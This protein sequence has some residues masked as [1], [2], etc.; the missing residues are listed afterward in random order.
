MSTVSG[1]RASG[2]GLSHVGKVRQRNEDSLAIDG[3]G[4]FVL[5]ADGMGGHKG[6]MEASRMTIDLV[7]EALD[8]LH[9]KMDTASDD[10]VRNFL[11]ELF[12]KTSR[13]VHD[14]GAKDPLLAHMGTTLVVWMIC[15]NE[16]KLAHVGD[17]RAYLVRDGEIFLISMDHTFVN[18]Q[19]AAGAE[20]DQ[21]FGGSNYKNAIFRNIGMMPPSEPSIV[22]GEP[23][24]GDLWILCSDGL[25]NKMT[26]REMLEIVKNHLT[27]EEE[28]T[29]FFADTCRDLV[30]LA[31]DR[32]GEDNISVLFFSVLKDEKSN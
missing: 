11:R 29:Q 27:L 21:L 25:S 9:S 14:R 2:F 5:V 31:L 12:Q 28:R 22:S 24:E 13:Q 30:Q 15:G 16:F 17:S 19:I 26:G 32:G 4:R 20:R 23:C 10:N 3:E 1:W 6:G 18:E 7:S 8:K